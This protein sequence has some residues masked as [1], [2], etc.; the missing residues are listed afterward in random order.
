M[1]QREQQEIKEMSVVDD[2]HFQGF[3][4]GYTKV[5]HPQVMK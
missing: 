5:S 4:L 3:L 1:L 2:E